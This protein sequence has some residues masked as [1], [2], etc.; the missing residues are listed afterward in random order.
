MMV[1][2]RTALVIGEEGLERLKSARVA[3]IGLGGVGSYAAEAL[4]RVNIGHI[5]LWDFDVIEVSNLNRQLPA[6]HSTVGQKKVDVVRARGEGINPEAHFTVVD[7]RFSGETHQLLL[8]FAPDF[9][10]DAIDSMS[11][12]VDL[13]ACCLDH[14]ISVISVMGAGNKLDPTRFRI[15]PLDKTHTDPL[16][17]L[18]RKIAKEK[19]WPSFPVV[20]SDEAPVRKGGGPVGSLSFVPSAAG[21]VAASY[22]VRSLLDR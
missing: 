8:D 15:S 19:E 2:S 16:A 7:R 20:W 5:L 13:L 10:V 4:I 22:V 1:N 6:L 17:K 11:D 3:I 18:L 14:G 12:K 9:V 21:L